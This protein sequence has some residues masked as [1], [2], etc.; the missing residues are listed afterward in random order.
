MEKYSTD[1]MASLIPTTRF[2]EISKFMVIRRTEPVPKIMYNILVL[3]FGWS[4]ECSV[5]DTEL[6]FSH[7]Y[8]PHLLYDITD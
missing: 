7:S 1:F 8:L 6:K 2:K 4:C 3:F 5:H